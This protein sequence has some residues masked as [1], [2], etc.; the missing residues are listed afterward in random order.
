[1]SEQNHQE[2]NKV[3]WQLIGSKFVLALLILVFSGFTVFIAFNLQAD[4]VPDEPF[5]FGVSRNFAATLGV[6]DPEPVTRSMGNYIRQNPYLAYWIYGRALNVFE[7]IMPTASNWQQ[8]VFLRLFNSLFSIGT[9]I[10]VYLLS[11]ELIKN[12]WWQLLPV[13]ALTNTL[14]FVLL[15]G[16]VNYDNPANMFCA[17]GAYFLVRV[18][19]GSDFLSNSF[20]WMIFIALGTWTKET[21]LPLAL[22][23]AVVWGIFV[24]QN[25]SK[26]T[27]WPGIN[28]RTI[29][30][31]IILTIVLAANFSIYGMN[32]I[33]YQSVT[34]SCRDVY[35][36]EFCLNTPL[37]RRRAELALPE[38]PTVLQAFRQGYPEPIRYG[39][40]IW[41]R[42]MLMKIFGIMGGQESY[43]PI[44]ISYFHIL[45]FWM[46]A[47]MVRYFRKTTF[48]F[49]SLI[50][51][52]GFY[53]ITLFIK[54]YDTDLAYG[55][56]QV[57]H[58]GR[59]IFP[60]IGIIFTLFSYGLFKVPNRWIKYPTLI[61][62]LFL[63]IYSGPIRF[64]LYYRTVFANWFV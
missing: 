17:A 8:L 12:I 23:M 3:S 30:L 1:M 59:Y 58:Q 45:F 39:F 20:L 40:D 5:H 13:F 42:A 24:Y 61:V 53:A 63:F 52:V 56:I 33:R 22:V 27:F 19:K 21:I 25:W 49:Y 28:L 10:F 47:L 43:Y 50:A 15:S 26:I 46:M 4:I 16:G 57:A 55:F 18:F 6:P 38:K 44:N 31:I 48:T 41:I 54:N 37:A 29:T 62:T 7:R 64:L 51:I 9:L 60:V 32:I 11:K 36:D 35:T 14:M 2:K 34:P